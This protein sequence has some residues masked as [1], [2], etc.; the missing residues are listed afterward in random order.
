[1]WCK[2]LYLQVISSLDR[3]ASRLEQN[4]QVLFEAGILKLLRPLL[5]QAELY[6]K[7]FATKLLS[8]LNYLPAV[9]DIL[10]EEEIIPFM[11]EVLNS[12][13]FNLYRYIL[14]YSNMVNIY[15]FIV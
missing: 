13:S 8:E 6:I 4:A 15:T 12:V 10:L 1:M 14:H 9:A 7:R 2:T 5:D 11:M 3:Y